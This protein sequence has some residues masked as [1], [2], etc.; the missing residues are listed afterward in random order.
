MRKKQPFVILYVLLICLCLL[1]ILVNQ[2][3][4]NASQRSEQNDE[5]EIE[6]FRSRLVRPKYNVN[7]RRIFELDKVNQIVCYSNIEIFNS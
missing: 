1:I 4:Q 6:E 3:R 5:S 2:H 7:C